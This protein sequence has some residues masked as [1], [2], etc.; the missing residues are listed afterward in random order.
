MG[1]VVIFESD[2]RTEVAS[3]RSSEG[4][5]AAEIISAVTEESCFLE[6]EHGATLFSDSV[7]AAGKYVLRLKKKRRKGVMGRDVRPFVRLLIEKDNRKL[8]Q[9][10]LKCITSTELGLVTTLSSFARLA[11][12]MQQASWTMESIPKHV[13]YFFRTSDDSDIAISPVHFD[14]EKDL[15]LLQFTQDESGG[16]PDIPKAGF[17]QEPPEEA[18]ILILRW[19]PQVSVEGH[20][21]VDRV[22]VVGKSFQVDGAYVVRLIPHRGCCGGGVFFASNGELAGV[23]QR[24]LQKS[25]QGSGSGRDTFARL[26]VDVE[27]DGIRCDL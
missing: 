23:H 3:V 21:L 8:S 25:E 19:S 11:K 10:A 16:T 2:G 14:I 5:S 27:E 24:I 9:T 18:G 6:D 12:E 7:V 22:N 13:H 4:R 15:I 17:S 26:R 20:M 1:D